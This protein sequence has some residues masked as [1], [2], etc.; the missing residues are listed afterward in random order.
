MPLS[1][2]RAYGVR[3][4]GQRFV[5]LCRLAIAKGEVD[6]LRILGKA[7]CSCND[8]PPKMVDP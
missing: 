3:F 4:S 1:L 7:P 6:S 2:E 5:C 8:K